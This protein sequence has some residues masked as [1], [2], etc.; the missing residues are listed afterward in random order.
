MLVYIQKQPPM[1]G[2]PELEAN[3]PYAVVLAP[4]REL[5]QQVGGAGGQRGLCEVKAR[6]A[7]VGARETGA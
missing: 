2:N 7:G 6:V 5:A 4:T 3:G 1:L